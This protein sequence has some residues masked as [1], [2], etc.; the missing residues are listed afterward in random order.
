MYLHIQ[1]IMHNTQQENKFINIEPNMY[2]YS[3]CT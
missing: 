1:F 3:L 2:M